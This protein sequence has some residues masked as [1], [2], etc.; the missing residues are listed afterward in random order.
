MNGNVGIDW[1][2]AFL[3]LIT[4]AVTGIVCRSR[5]GLRIPYVPHPFYGEYETSWWL[6][7]WFPNRS[8]RFSREPTLDDPEAAGGQ[9]EDCSAPPIARVRTDPRSRGCKIFQHEASPIP[10]Y[11]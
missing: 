3:W 10:E 4:A 1:V 11:K 5:G 8:W 6:T 7:G 9:V 2:N